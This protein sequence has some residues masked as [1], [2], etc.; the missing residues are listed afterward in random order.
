M[1]RLNISDTHRSAIYLYCIQAEYLS[2][3]AEIGSTEQVPRAASQTA[4]YELGEWSWVLYSF[5]SFTGR[6]PSCL[7]RTAGNDNI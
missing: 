1:T 2:N 7:V 5:D 4:V 6:L 3:A